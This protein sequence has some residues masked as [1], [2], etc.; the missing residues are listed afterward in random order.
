MIKHFLGWERQHIFVM[1]KTIP[2]NWESDTLPQFSLCIWALQKSGLLVRDEES[3]SP[4]YLQGKIKHFWQKPPMNTFLCFRPGWVT[5]P[6]EVKVSWSWNWSA[7]LICILCLTFVRPFCPTKCKAR[8]RRRQVA[9]KV[10]VT[11]ILRFA[12]SYKDDQASFST[13]P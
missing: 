2:V 1:T 4:T 7:M 12:L 5:P 11:F 10:Q 6:K 8:R 3:L 9:W 13:S